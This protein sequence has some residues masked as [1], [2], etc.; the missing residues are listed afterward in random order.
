MDSKGE[1]PTLLVYDGEGSME[2][3]LKELASYQGICNNKVFYIDW[4][5]N[6][7]DFAR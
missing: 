6:E 2:T 5:L 3:T 4:E 1:N 7:Q